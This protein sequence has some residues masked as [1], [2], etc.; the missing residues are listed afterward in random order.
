M[1]LNNIIKLALSDHVKVPF[2]QLYVI[3]NLCKFELIPHQIIY[4]TPSVMSLHV[5]KMLFLSVFSYVTKKHN[6]H[7]NQCINNKQF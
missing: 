6:I 7:I 5:F 3:Q 4:H 1:H 2:L